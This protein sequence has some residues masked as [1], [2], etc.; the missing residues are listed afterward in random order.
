MDLAFL[1]ANLVK[2]AYGGWLPLL[3]A[4]CVYVTMT[5]WKRGRELLG[6]RVRENLVPLEDFWELLRVELPARVPGTAVFMTSNS[7]GTPPAMLFNFMHNHVVHDH[8]VLLTVMTMQTAR[9]A[10]EERLSVEVMKEGVVRVVGRYGFMETPDVPLLLEQANLPG[11]VPEHTTFFLGREAVVTER[12][13]TQLRLSLFSLLSRNA[14]SATAF[15]NIPP[16]RVMEIGSQVQ[17]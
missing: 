16:D 17:L 2:I 1:G 9:V 5:S 3:I 10:P 11:S 4:G 6:A 8:V 14:A 15:F 7:E 13:L 12:R